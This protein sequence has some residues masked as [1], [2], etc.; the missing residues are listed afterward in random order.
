MAMAQHLC[1][2]FTQAAAYSS[3]ESLTVDQTGRV[4]GPLVS[5][6]GR[7]PSACSRRGARG[8]A[9]PHGSVA[10]R[11]LVPAFKC[12]LAPADGSPI[13]S[14]ARV[15]GSGN[16]N[17]GFP[18]GPETCALPFVLGVAFL[19]NCQSALAISDFP[20]DLLGVAEFGPPSSGS[21]GSG[22]DGGSGSSGGGGG[23]GGGS[24]GGTGSSAVELTVDDEEE[25][26]KEESGEQGNW[27]GSYLPFAS[28]SSSV[29]DPKPTGP[30]G[31]QGGGMF[32]WLA[33]F[34]HSVVGS[35]LSPTEKRALMVET[36][37]LVI[38]MLDKRSSDDPYAHRSEVSA[39]RR[40]QRE[41]FQ[42]LLRMRERLE[43]MESVN[44]VRRG[45]GEGSTG[46]FTSSRLFPGE[47][48]GAFGRTRLTGH[49]AAGGAYV[50]TE[51]AESHSARAALEQAGMRS[52]L[53]VKFSFETVCRGDAADVLLTEATAGLGE[54]T[55]SFMLGGPLNLSKVLYATEVSDGVRLTLAP[56]GATGSDIADP[57]NPL[58]G[59]GLTRFS[60][61]GM[62]LHRRTNGSAVG[63]N[64]HNNTVSLTAAQFLSGWGFT[65][66]TDGDGTGLCSSTLAQ[67]SLQPRDDVVVSFSAVQRM[68][69]APPLPS[70]PGLHWSEMGPLV[71]PRLL[72]WAKSNKGPAVPT[73]SESISSGGQ[74]G[75]IGQD[76][77][78][79]LQPESPTTLQ[80]LAVAGAFKVGP[81]T[82]LAAWM[83]AENAEWLEEEEKRRLQWSVSLIHKPESSTGASDSIWK[84]ST[85]GLCLGTSNPD[86][87]TTPS[88]GG[89]NGEEGAPAGPTGQFQA[90]AFA[91]IP[92]GQGLSL[93]PG[94]IWTSSKAYGQHPA[95]ML[96]CKWNL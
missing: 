16:K 37:D 22:G 56:L 66:D 30:D 8:L 14:S 76:P 10:S 18:S 89:A 79:S 96:R 88:G 13:A 5:A 40:L 49:V 80:S 81:R 23:G 27:I 15:Q 2:K 34:L 11:R 74:A 48:S 42:D 91:T 64:L 36:A 73:E 90:E 65:N 78:A 75:F 21:G 54:E 95:F 67:L 25:Q 52:G 51:G 92:V 72:P 35:S 28:V 83:Q 33:T 85:Y 31:S 60:S 59:Q 62:P 71:V 19:A 93:Q 84:K 57:I 1:S 61:G 70:S 29:G 50:P 12:S 41:A 58:E 55:S 3:T 26:G 4:A 53:A 39:L 68:W 45:L 44:F 9:L 17:S 7:S 77:W 6:G 38:E 87:F 86:A 82:A 24:E 32:D 46:Q 43:K 63:V 94:A 20:Q 69:P 47:G